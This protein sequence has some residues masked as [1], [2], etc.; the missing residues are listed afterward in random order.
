MKAHDWV[1]VEVEVLDAQV[2]DF[3][4]AGAGV[5]EEQDHRHV[6]LKWLMASRRAFADECAARVNRT[7]ELLVDLSPLV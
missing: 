1:L 3:L 2:G 5:I 6:V 4:H 7:V